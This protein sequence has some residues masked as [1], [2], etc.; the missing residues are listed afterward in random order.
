M[1]LSRSVSSIGQRAGGEQHRALTAIGFLVERGLLAFEQRQRTGPIAG[2]AAEFEH[3]LAGPAKRRVVARRFFG[4]S[5]GAGVIAAPLRL[6]EQAAQAER[7][8]VGAARHIAEN[9]VG[10][11]AIAAELRRLCAQ[12]QRQRFGRRQTLGVGGVLA[13]RGEIAGADRNQPARD[14]LIGAFTAA[15]GANGFSSSAA[16]ARWRGPRST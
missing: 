3:G 2:E 1:A 16:S 15:A 8:G 14:R 6:D 7:L 12:Q 5:M 4:K 10:R 13:R 11:V 9:A